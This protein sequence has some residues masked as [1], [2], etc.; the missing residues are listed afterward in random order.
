MTI[1]RVTAMLAMLLFG[2]V[3]ALGVGRSTHNNC[4]DPHDGMPTLPN[5]PTMPA[6]THQNEQ[7]CNLYCEFHCH[8]D[9]DQQGNVNAC[10]Q[11]KRKLG[12]HAM[13][14]DCH[15]DPDD[16]GGQ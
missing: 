4:A 7:N 12:M 2:S 6:W 5:M 1:L 15:V 16:T 3:T 10:N 9:E 8:K 11:M 13:H 14:I